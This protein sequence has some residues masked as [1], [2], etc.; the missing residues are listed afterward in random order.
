MKTWHRPGLE[1]VLLIL[2]LILEQP[3]GFL[4]HL[5]QRPGE[6]HRGKLL[7][8]RRDGLIH[9]VAQAEVAAVFGEFRDP[10]CRPHLPSGIEGLGRLH[11]HPP[12]FVIRATRTLALRTSSETGFQRAG[13]LLRGARR[14]PRDRR[15]LIG[16][17]TRSAA[18]RR[19]APRAALEQRLRLLIVTAG[20]RDVWQRLR[21]DFDD[22]APSDFDLLERLE[23]VWILLQG[24][25]HRIVERKIA[26]DRPDRPAPLARRTGS[27]AGGE[28]C[29]KRHK[30]QKS[31]HWFWQ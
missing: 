28:E 14:D 21:T 22:L 12:G 1:T 10:D 11:R 7:P 9:C 23:D 18:R 20:Q 5:D 16:I 29:G 8:D 17:H 30:G 26:G 24:D 15:K 31:I 2:E 13:D 27:D 19:T 25:L 6:Q 4:L 3:H